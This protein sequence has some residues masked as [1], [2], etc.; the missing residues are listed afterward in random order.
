MAS[1]AESICREARSVTITRVSVARADLFGRPELDL[2]QG[3]HLRDCRRDPGEHQLDLLGGHRQG[4]GRFGLQGC[5]RRGGISAYPDIGDDSGESNDLRELCHVRMQPGPHEL[6]DRLVAEGHGLA[7][8]LGQTPVAD[9]PGPD[10][11]MVAAEGIALAPC[12]ARVIIAGVGRDPLVLAPHDPAQCQDSNVLEKGCQEGLVGGGETQRDGQLA[13]R[14]RREYRALPVRIEAGVL[15][16]LEVAHQRKRQR[17]GPDGVETQQRQRVLHGANFLPQS[18]HR[19]ID[20]PQDLGRQRRILRDRVGYLLHVE[21][22]ALAELQYAQRDG[23]QC[24]QGRTA[25]EPAAE[26]RA[27]AAGTFGI[28]RVRRR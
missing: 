7:N 1:W 13:S 22:I 28:R 11:G 4:L 8:R 18:E 12:E 2:E 9:Q 15:R 20:Q 27:E 16:L 21:I 10:I 17:Q 25:F 14:H 23:G 24:G 19:R 5:D 3:R 26:V 6:G